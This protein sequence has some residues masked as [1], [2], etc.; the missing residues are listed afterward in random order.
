MIAGFADSL[1]D[2][3]DVRLIKTNSAGNMEWSQTYGRTEKDKAYSVQ[4]TS[5]EEYIIAGTTYSFGA[6]RDPGFLV[7]KTDRAPISHRCQR[8]WNSQHQGPIYRL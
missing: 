6:S 5:D 1:S 4:Q 2:N 3:R 7:D 8:K